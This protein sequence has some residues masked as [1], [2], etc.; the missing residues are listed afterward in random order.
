MHGGKCCAG[1]AGKKAAGTYTWISEFL[2]AP[3]SAVPKYSEADDL[4][5]SLPQASIPNPVF[6]RGI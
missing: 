5:R 3:K 2:Q 1:L 6:S 4:S